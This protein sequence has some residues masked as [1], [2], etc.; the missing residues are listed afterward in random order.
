[1][2]GMDVNRESVTIIL[3]NGAS[4]AG[5]TTVARSLQKIMSAPY[6][7]VPVDSFA[8]MAPDA[9]QLGEPGSA[10]WQS[11]FNHLLSGFHHSLAALA[12]AGNNLIVDHVLVQGTE[13]QNWLEECLEVLA[14]FPVY[15]IGVRCPL[16]ELRRREQERGDR[17]AGLAEFQFSRVHRH[18]TYDLEVDTAVSSADQCALEIKAL[19]ESKTHPQ[20]FTNLRRR[21]GAAE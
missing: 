5:K 6:L 7:N 11:V 2:E 12:A 17:G 9:G 15:F 1:M 3:L 21:A 14:P 16:E 13:P 4:S 18:G 20:A 10:P 8:A 19:V